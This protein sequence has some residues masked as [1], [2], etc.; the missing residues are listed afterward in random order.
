MENDILIDD[1]FIKNLL[2]IKII[3]SN[4]N[5]WMVRTKKGFFYKEF[6]EKQFIAL[7]WNLVDDSNIKKFLSVK[8]EKNN[9]KIEEL[10]LKYPK[11]KRI[12]DLLSKCNRFINEIKEGDIIMIPSSTRGNSITFAVAGAYYEEEYCTYTMEK[13]IISSI[14][15]GLDKEFLLQCPYKKR[16]KIEVLKTVDGDKININL[17]KALVSHHGISR[18]DNYGRYILS[19]IYNVYY[20][21]DKMSIVFNIDL[22]ED[23]DPLH[24]SEFMY[25]I[26]SL[27]YSST[28]DIK[29]SSKTNLNSRGIWEVIVAGLNSSGD[30]ISS[31]PFLSTISIVFLTIVGGK[32]RN[33]EI[34]SLLDK[35]MEWRKTNSQ[36]KTE[37]L[38]REKKKC[39]IREMQIELKKKEKQGEIDNIRLEREKKCLEDIENAAEYLKVNKDSINKIINLPIINHEKYD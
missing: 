9:E 39:E 27:I 1:K 18:I 13:E 26:S 24:L 12:G 8:D 36:L 6:I 15:G 7:G 10:K 28:D 11:N 22:E 38:D 29:I 14:D 33:F 32:Y 25:N 35:I 34:N 19:S 2:D 37:D 23:I 3:D 4:I 16:R 31:I 5:F 20:W 21:K 17:Y 30:L